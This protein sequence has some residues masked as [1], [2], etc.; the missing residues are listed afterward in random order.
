MNTKRTL[1]L[2]VVAFCFFC[3][4]LL[5]NAPA[6]RAGTFSDAYQNLKDNYPG[7]IQQLKNADGTISDSDIESFVNDLSSELQSKGTLNESNLDSSFYEAA[8]NVMLKHQHEK[9]VN[10]ALT[11]FDISWGD[12]LSKNIPEGFQSI[13]SSLRTE[14]LKSSGTPA[15]GGGG[16]ILQPQAP[17]P[18]GAAAKVSGEALEQALQK[19]AETGVVK[20]NAGTSDR[21]VALDKEQL[22]KI[23]NESRPLLVEVQGVQISVPP[24]GL[25]VPEMAKP[26]IVQVELGARKLEG[27]EKPP[28]AALYR[29]VGDVFEISAVAVHQDGKRQ[30]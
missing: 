18:P 13:K 23:S 30:V 11:G 17:A 26:D 21:E 12:I 3:S 14:L 8:L 24:G 19:A 10:A 20:I 7:T 2:A 22:S 9:V 1:L 25:D 27:G 29:V 28:G 15:G 6:A 4:L 16:G 5:Q